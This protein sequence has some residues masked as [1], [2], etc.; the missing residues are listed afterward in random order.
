MG[1]KWKY[2][3][4]HVKKGE[5]SF[6]KRT[7][8]YLSIIIDGMD[9]KKTGI[10]F[11]YNGPKAVKELTPYKSSVVGVIVHGFEA[12]AFVV[13]PFWKHDSDLTIEILIRTFIRILEAGHKL[14]P[15]LYLQMDNCWRENKNQHVF[16]FL[17][18]LVKL[19]IF[20]KIKLNF[21][22]V[23]HTHEDIDQLFKSLN[24]VLKR[25]TVGTISKFISVMSEGYHSTKNIAFKVTRLDNVGSYKDWFGPLV[26]GMHNH[27]YPHCFKVSI[28]FFYETYDASSLYDPSFCSPPCVR[29]SWFARISCISLDMSKS[30]APRV[31]CLQMFACRYVIHPRRG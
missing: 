23:G 10:P 29:V 13:E 5:Q 9:Q 2:T 7:H 20:R 14:A 3:Q 11:A 12:R 31:I 26:Q 21:D 28:C 30:P 27:V 24:T 22:L 15:V 1:Q 17:A 19:N 6:E 8:K 16:T 4:K 18:I 25:S